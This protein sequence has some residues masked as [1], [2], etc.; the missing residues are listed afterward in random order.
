MGVTSH[1]TSELWSKEAIFAASI[2]A[3]LWE[4]GEYAKATPLRDCHTSETFCHCLNC[5]AV[6]TWLNRC[7]RF[8]CPLCCQRL[9]Y[10]RKKSIEAWAETIDQPKHLVLTARNREHIS[11]EYVKHFKTNL[12]KLRR[13]KLCSGWRGGLS[14]LEVTNEGKGWH[15]HAHLL[16]D[17][18]W[19]HISNISVAWAKLVRQDFAIVA[20]RD[21]REKSYLKEI[22]KYAV[23]GSELA[24]WSGRSARE[25]I[26]AMTGVRQFAVFGSL[27]KDRALRNQIA[28][29]LTPD[30]CSC[31]KC[32]STHLRFLDQHEENWM[33]E[34]GHWPDRNW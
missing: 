21:C 11:N 22:C 2:A 28:A 3:K 27:Y 17:V 5:G 6:Q 26:D 20:V 7:D 9:A 24:S 1:L 33:Q 8:Y 18:D 4:E 34:T 10:R 14:S 15:L 30:K 25:Y 12:S 32:A 23:K 29:E 19:L 16:V 31:P 13:L